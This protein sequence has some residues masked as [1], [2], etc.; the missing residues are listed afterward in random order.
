MKQ[1]AFSAIVSFCLA[2]FAPAQS[3][4]T[5][6]DAA[7]RQLGSSSFVQRELAHKKL[8]SI[9]SPALEAMRRATKSA[10]AET[11]R[12]L[13]ALIRDIEERL[14]TK[15]ILD[16][17]E[18]RLQVDA[19]SVPQAIAELARVSGYPIQFLGD[20]TK[21]ADRKI[22]LDTGVTSF[23]QAFDQLCDEAGLMERVELV[24]Q[25]NVSNALNERLSGRR[26]PNQTPGTIVVTPRT[27]EKSAVSYAGAVKTALRL[28]RSAST[29]EMTLTLLVSA[30]P[31]LLNVGLAGTPRFK[32]IVDQQLRPL[33][34]E[35]EPRQP[36]P[37]GVPVNDMGIDLLGMMVTDRL[38]RH[39][40]IRV[41]DGESTS[42]Q[43]SELLGELTIQLDL[44]NETIARV[45]KILDA[46]GKSADGANGGSM[47]VGSV[48]KLGNG[49]V[50]VQVALENLAPNPFGN[51]LII[52]GGNVIIRG[53]VNING[54]MIGGRGNIGQ[55]TD[56]PDLL[57]A[58]GQKFKIAA[59]TSESTHIN[60]GS[61]S[62]QCTIVYQ[63]NSGQA[64]AT[65]L[66]LFGSRTHTI[67]A[68]FRFADVALPAR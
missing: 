17:K 58:K 60:N 26:T 32:R 35:P 51:N 4:S 22:T 12:R 38:P 54:V 40:Q 43:L 56:L 33:A 13:D 53:N 52:N 68:P 48:K 41:K 50:E 11:K 64:E 25:S 42:K 9:G 19:V 5:P 55:R 31:R 1:W 61:L 21:L 59:V 27:G 3:T 49:N 63:P 29:K 10:D 65:S 34:S 23:W 57:D 44:Q 28:S 18:V 46:G 30:E 62:R 66:I 14:L 8:E 20:A 47:K 15:Q 36:A 7:I 45:E 67:A 39:I 6:I 37:A 16:P 2:S 24:A